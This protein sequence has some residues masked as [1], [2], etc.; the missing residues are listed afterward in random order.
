MQHASSPTVSVVIPAYNAEGYVRDAVT[1][2]IRQTYPLQEIVCVDDGST[3]GTLKVLRRLEA[4]HPDH[5]HVMTGPNRGASAARNRGIERVTGEYIQFLDADDALLPEKL[6][7]D[8][9]VLAADQASVL[10]GGYE[11]FEGGEKV[12]EC[13]TYVSKDPWICLAN[14]NFGHTSANLFRAHAVREVG[15]WDEERP[16]NQDYD[17]I[18]RILMEGGDVAFGRHK[19]TRVC[20]RKDSISAEWGRDERTAQL[21]LDHDV[22]RHLRAREGPEKRVAAVEDAVFIKLRRL[23]QLDPETA[24]RLYREIFPDG[25][26]PVADKGNTV[27]YCAI[28]RV[29]GFSAAEQ[30]KTIYRKVRP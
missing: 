25:H 8:L 28:H 11:S 13:A 18:A 21:K 5:V 19:Y 27:S 26:T 16:F 29:L 2:A 20:C 22:L 23:Y 1:S 12:H 10:F 24:V 15:G 4:Q 9:D 6:E 3:D 30:L 14:Q 17:L 7:Q